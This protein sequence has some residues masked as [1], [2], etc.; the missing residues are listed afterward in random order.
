MADQDEGAQATP[1]PEDEGGT[2]LTEGAQ[3]DAAPESE[4]SSQEAQEPEASSDDGDQDE[5]A[6]TA[7]D[8]YES[9][10]L[11]DGFS[12]DDAALDKITPVFKELGLNQD[13]AQ[14]LVTAYSELQTTSQEAQ[15]EA[16]GQTLK[17]WENTVRNHET[18][19]GDKLEASLSD[20]ARAIDTV[21]GDEADQFRQFLNESGMGNHPYMFE[22]LVKVGKGMSEDGYA[23]AAGDGAEA[24]PDE[25]AEKHYP[26]M[27]KK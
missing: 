26:S 3:A 9:F 15:A 25:I 16:W 20:A 13:Q 8:E 1:A 5:G 23:Q 14:S 22:L 10:T 11:P 21:F 7:P 18:L 17:S 4:D 19:G 2:V 27:V 6:N 12:V 24:S